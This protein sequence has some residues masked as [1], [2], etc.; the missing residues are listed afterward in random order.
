[1]S[2]WSVAVPGGASVRA[3][4]PT[5][6]P[7]PPSSTANRRPVPSGCGP[8]GPTAMCSATGGRSRLTAPPDQLSS[9]L[10]RRRQA[11]IPPHGATATDGEVSTDAAEE[12][13]GGRPSAF[14]GA[15]FRH[16]AIAK[17]R[18]FGLPLWRL[19][20]CLGRA[21][22]PPQVWRAA[23]RFCWSSKPGVWGS[24]IH[25]RACARTQQCACCPTLR[26]GPCSSGWRRAP[27]RRRRGT[28]DQPYQSGHLDVSH[29]CP[30]SDHVE[31]LVWRRSAGTPVRVGRS[32]R[33]PSS[34]ARRCF[35]RSRGRSDRRRW[36]SWTACPTRRSRRASTRSRRGAGSTTTAASIWRAAARSD[37]PPRRARRADREPDEPGGHL[38]P[39]RGDRPRAG[40]RD[41]G[42]PPRRAVHVAPDRLLERPGR[43]DSAI[44]WAR[45]RRRRCGR[46]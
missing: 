7:G 4:R 32:Q 29:R 5:A 14:V 27:G 24:Q 45:D 8:V 44:A 3:G 25:S 38:P 9:Y 41:G 23:R 6:R 2:A 11:Q 42:E 26:R 39:R 10:A 31:S 21:Y 22:A 12:S 36:T 16:H 43:P 28:R 46:S 34:R 35:A 17:A 30:R 33:R 13:P 20:P 40:R 1:M 18:G 15:R 37:R 19:N